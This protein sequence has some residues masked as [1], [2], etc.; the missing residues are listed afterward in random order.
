MKKVRAKKHLGQH[1]LTQTEI[2]NDIAH[3]ISDK[4]SVKNVLEIGP[5]TGILTRALM[6]RERFNLKLI[7]IDSESV[8]HLHE[9]HPELG[10]S[11]IEGDFLKMD[12]TT[13]FE[14]NAFILCGN[15]PYNISSQI[16]FRIV[17]NKDLIPE[18]VGM[19]QK[20]VAE[21]A[22]AKHGSKTYGILSV[23]I[24]AYYDSGYLF[25]VDEGAFEPPPKVKSG[26]IRLVRNERK[27]LPIPYSFFKS[28]VKAAFNQRRKTLRNSLSAFLDENLKSELSETLKL[29]PEQMSC[30][31]FVEL[32]TRLQK[33]KG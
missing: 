27:E 1:F 30:E 22:I 23:L 11:I 32:A 3:G 29:R 17:E 15:F 12:L 19:F 9:R 7:E 6:A 28:M 31:S 4:E 21:R 14:G 26:V 18:M 5:G 20:E 2:A 33:D 10:S 8:Q 16:L 13:I 24:R 25:T